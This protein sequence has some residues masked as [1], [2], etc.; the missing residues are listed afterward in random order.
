MENK[1]IRAEELSLI[2]NSSL[3]EKQIGL[4][5]KVTPAK[6]V[7]ERPGKGG[8]KWKFVSGGYV[9][10]CLNLMFGFDWDFEVVSYEKVE[11]QVV[12]LG[13]LTCRS[14][15]RTIIKMQFGR[16]DIKFK[17]DSLEMLDFGNDLKGACTDSL[18]KCGSE[19]GIAADI[20]NAE[21]F[22]QMEIIDY[23]TETEKLQTLKDLFAEKGAKLSDSLQKRVYEIIQNTELNSY[24]KVIKT[25]T[26]L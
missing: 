5:L 8:Q 13:K 12:V 24:D 16:Q 17:R 3:S 14:N 23:N 9:K 7:K 19:I 2:E 15:G 10:K 20:F 18:K 11:K 1:L 21:E 22:E 6:Y 4:L 26:D 25:L